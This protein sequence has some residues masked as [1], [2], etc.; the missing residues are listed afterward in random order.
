[1]TL[2]AIRYHCFI[3]NGTSCQVHLSLD[4]RTFHFHFNVLSLAMSIEVGLLLNVVVEEWPSVPSLQCLRSLRCRRWTVNCTL[5]EFIIWTDISSGALSFATTAGLFVPSLRALGRMKAITDIHID[6]LSCPFLPPSLW[7]GE[8]IIWNLLCRECF[9]FLH[10]S[11]FEFSKAWTLRIV[12]NNNECCTTSSG[13][14]RVRRTMF[15]ITT[16][17]C[18]R[19]RWGSF[20]SSRRRSHEKKGY[21]KLLLGPLDSLVMN[22]YNFS[23]FR[24]SMNRC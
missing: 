1:M 14:H 4:R 3:I 7:Y 2:I 23:C 24:Y 8:V 22:S 10:Q 5:H 15:P 11:I 13:L 20:T 9:C 12:N 18:Y 21:M 16:Q 19:N 6:V 17:T